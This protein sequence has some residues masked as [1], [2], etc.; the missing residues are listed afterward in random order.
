MKEKVKIYLATPVHSN[1]SIHYMQSVVRFQTECYKQDIDFTLDMMKSSLV[2]QGRNTCVS[3]FL[4]TDYT[5]L[6]FIDSDILFYPESIIKMINKNVEVCSIP[7]PMKII[8]WDK[9]FD[10]TGD[11]PSMNKLQKSTSGNKFPVKIKE[12]ENDVTM[13]NEMIELDYAPT[14]CLLLQ[15]QVFDKLIKTYP[16]KTIHQEN[17]VDGKMIKKQNLYNFFDTYYDEKEKR[18]YGEDFA[19]S[20][21]W[22]KTG[23]KCMALITEYITHVGEYQYTGRLL[24]EMIPVGLDR[25]E[26]KS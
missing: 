11:L 1:V 21:L 15:R 10:K 12:D 3:H 13:V 25:Q 7:Y 16:N 2:T 19:F 18:Y 14:G 24:D 22:R 4:N 8:N 23:G 17:M 26:K 9:V 6:L 20:R 5:H